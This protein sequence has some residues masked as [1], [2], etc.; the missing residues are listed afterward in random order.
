NCLR[1]VASGLGVAGSHGKAPYFTGN[2]WTGRSRFLPAI[3]GL[4]GVLARLASHHCGAAV[5]TGSLQLR[6]LALAEILQLALA[7]REAF[8][9]GFLLGSVQSAQRTL[10][11]HRAPHIHALLVP[12]ASED[13][14]TASG[15]GCF[16]ALGSDSKMQARHFGV[17]LGQ[18]GLGRSVGRI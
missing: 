6:V 4:T 2:G 3:P 10:A 1:G 11:S 17:A 18:I 5:A 7:L 14:F 15:R 13:E 12:G 16:S 9:R 8:D